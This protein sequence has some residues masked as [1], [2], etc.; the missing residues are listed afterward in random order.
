MKTLVR[1]SDLHFGCVD[2]FLLAPLRKS[3]EEIRPAL[4]AV[5]VDLTQRT[6]KG[7]LAEASETSQANHG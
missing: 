5:S 4:I 1:L 3:I 2:T 6:G 7:W